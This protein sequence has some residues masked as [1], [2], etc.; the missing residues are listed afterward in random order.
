MP[1][2]AD[3]SVFYIPASLFVT[4]PVAE[5]RLFSSQQETLLQHQIVFSRFIRPVWAA[6]EFTVDA[7]LGADAGRITA[8]HDVISLDAMAGYRF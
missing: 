5:K 1:T 4:P 7:E 3:I 6:S 2:R 8:D